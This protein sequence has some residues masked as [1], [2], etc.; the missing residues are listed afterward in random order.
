MYIKLF[1]YDILKDMCLSMLYSNIT[2]KRTTHETFIPAIPERQLERNSKIREKGLPERCR[3][4]V[5][6]FQN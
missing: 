1:E 4:L 6:F 2:Y 5:F 3:L